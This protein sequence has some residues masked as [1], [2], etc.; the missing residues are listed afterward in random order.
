MS[1][2]EPRVGILMGS[3]SD[4]EVMKE[5]AKALEELD[6]S[7]RMTV[8]SAHRTPAR[9]GRELRGPRAAAGG[10]GSG[11]ARHS[12]YSLRERGPRC[13]PDLR[14]AQLTGILG[15]CTIASA[16]RVADST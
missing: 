8:A 14:G 9:V 6:V 3:A 15:C 4:L 10:R 1:S 2:K 16:V 11:G 12:E 5:A 13:Q 7:F